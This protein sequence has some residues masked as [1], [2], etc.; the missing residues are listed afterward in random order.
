[1]CSPR[2]SFLALF[3]LILQF[4]FASLLGQVLSYTSIPFDVNEG[5]SSS[6]TFDVMRDDRGFVWISTSHGVDRFDGHVFR[7]YSLTQG[8]DGVRQMNDG[9]QHHL[10][11]DDGG[12]LYCYTDRGRI[13]RY[14]AV[15]D[16]FIQVAS[17]T[18]LLEHHSL[19]AVVVSGG[20]ML[21]GVYNGLYS[22]ALNSS[23]STRHFIPTHNV[24]CIIPFAD[25]K[26]L[27]GSDHGVDCLD[28]A[29]ERCDAFTCSDLDVKSL[30]LD[31]VNSRLWIGTNG[32][33]LWSLVASDSV[34]RQE[35]DFRTAI[36]NDIAMY[37]DGL[38]LVGTDG[39]G[40]LQLSCA[41]SIRLQK[42]ATDALDSPYR[43]S[44][45]GIQDVFVDE[46]NI[47]IATWGG[48][49]TLLKAASMFMCLAHPNPLSP[50][51][52]RTNDL[53]TDT[54]GHLWVAYN[55][56][57]A[58]FDLQTG[59]SRFF[60]NRQANFLSVKAAADG[61]IW[62]AGYNSGLYRLDTETGHFQ[63][64]T[65]I[66]GSS[67]N[68]SIYSLFIDNDQNLW[69]GGLYTN[70]TCIPLSGSGNV[71]DR[72]HMTSYGV[73][74]VNDITQLGDSLILAAT[75]NGIVMLNR[76]NGHVSSIFTEADSSI[77]SGSNYISSVLSDSCG[78]IYA[79][80]DGAGL[81]IY[82]IYNRTFRNYNSRDGFPGNHLR[83]MVIQ[84][85]SML[86]ISTEGN[87]IFSFNLGQ[88]RVQTRLSRNSGLTSE[89]FFNHSAAS[90]PDGTIVFG[91]RSGAEVI[92][93]GIGGPD[94]D[95][96]CIMLDAPLSDADQ[97]SIPYGERSL[98]LSFT[99]NDLYH[100]ND[101]RF[102]YRI[103][104]SDEED[105]WLML[106]QNRTLTL[107]SL[108]PGVHRLT[109][110]CLSGSGAMVDKVIT[111]NVGQ[112]PW[113]QWP[114]IVCYV[115]LFGLL[116][117]ASVV[118]Y[119]KHVE[120][121]AAAE[122]IH[123]FS[124]VAHDIRTPLSLVSTPLSD[125]E[126][127]V[128][129]DV[130]PTLLPL[131]KRNLQHL[132]DVVDQLSL[133]NSNQQ[134]VQQLNPEPVLLGQFVA[135]L[136][137]A[138]QPMALHRG[139]SLAVEVP[140]D[141]VWVKADAQA[142][143]RICDN[144]VANA[145]KYT[146]QGSITIRV[147]RSAGRGLIEVRDTGIGMSRAT[148][149]MLFHHFFRGDNA[150]RSNIPGLGLGLMYSYQAARQMQGRL[151]CSSVEGKGSTFTL[152]LPLSET[153]EAHAYSFDAQ[154]QAYLEDE[155]RTLYSGYRYNVL[156]VEDNQELL[157]YLQQKLSKG[158]NVST[159]RCVAEANQLLDE[160]STD[161]ILTDVMM[162]G[163]RGDEWCRQLKSDIATSHIPVI[164]L[165]AMTGKE[166][167]LEGLSAGADDYITKPFDI[168]M[169]L[170]KVMNMF[171]ARRRLRT[172]YMQLLQRESAKSQVEVRKELESKSTQST[173][174]DQFV[175]RLMQ[176][177]ERNIGNSGL[178]VDDVASQMAMSHT[179]FYEKVNKLLGMPPA[180]LIRQCRMKRAKA[181]LLEGGHSVSEV[182]MLCGYT[183]AKYFSATFRKYY[184]TLPSKIG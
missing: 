17:V 125:L 25:G 40:L 9:K 109:V 147:I 31:S 83:G 145:M 110:R 135:S 140:S 170:I 45:A 21:V 169:L 149:R 13:F 180:S 121:V 28:L 120:N 160:H 103:D 3:V 107:Y 133:F 55:R 99:T 165:T 73:S 82:N 20:C 139:L 32:S 30:F 178:Q 44:A 41:G 150:V 1:M 162:P 154:S 39:D 58:E 179:L 22:I 51:D 63:H 118:Y 106:D 137:E 158:Y 37:D 138:Y 117:L 93:P 52:L 100:Q 68:N 54:L 71:L 91:G 14:D 124:S 112:T 101:M 164:L 27:V 74:R 155:S 108:P 176:V 172:H 42:L 161:L 143:W 49:V 174:D 94:I 46:D 111:L 89:D 134:N 148:M 33:G 16:S 57:I 56:A 90:L 95:D 182:A 184:G 64:F 47:W 142:L 62:C 12:I 153:G 70:L 130:P 26:F 163:M 34:A 152:W 141:D 48:G 81:L 92:S 146:S 97:I 156:L 136:S 181:L 88:K 36:I 123:F 80:T 85:D 10:I 50:A 167:Q 78:N 6:I 11:K 113:L 104:E 115:L 15:A 24:R 131:I 53:C 157:D 128:S 5:L 171:D 116:V 126:K 67:V 19:H 65:S 177:L 29:T 175:T 144:L 61:G 60:H 132:R 72:G 129:D 105:S 23:D 38:M 35:P 159:A 7:H 127:Y 166:Q 114:A 119:L 43:L 102:V 18:H 8:S 173:L 79:A 86:W 75:S 66:D 183:D 98:H 151:T 59:E 168:N 122:K 84:G 69:V 87:G 2:H 96:L 76:H 4:A 77:W